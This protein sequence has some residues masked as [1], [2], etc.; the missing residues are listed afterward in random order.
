MLDNVSPTDR[1]RYNAT[2]GQNATL[3]VTNVQVSDAIS[4]GCQ[5][6]DRQLTA[7][8]KVQVYAANVTNAMVYSEAGGPATV[9]VFLSSTAESDAYLGS[10]YQG[11]F[12]YGAK[13][14]TPTPN[15]S[16]FI[17]LAKRPA[18]PFDH[19]TLHELVVSTPS[20]KFSGPYY[21]LL[22]KNPPA[23]VNVNINNTA[24]NYCTF[25]NSENHFSTAM[26]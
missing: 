26:L 7:Q 10:W 3:T 23:Y 9:R 21:L 11:T 25:L 15:V 12:P 4:I 14:M 24:L 18:A 17:Q 19:Q 8:L 16:T 5:L 6:T 22:F 13:V 2:S 20:A 1:S